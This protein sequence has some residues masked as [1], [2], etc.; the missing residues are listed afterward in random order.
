MG[1]RQQR[2]E[3][4][5]GGFGV[6]APALA[7][8][9]GSRAQVEAA[10]VGARQSG[11]NQAISALT[12]LA[13]F[14]TEERGQTL[15]ALLGGRT[16]DVNLTTGQTTNI[17]NALLQLAGL[18]MPQIVAGQQSSGSQSKFSGL[19]SLLSLASLAA[20]P[21]TGGASLGVGAGLGA[22]T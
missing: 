19:S 8:A 1:L 18:S 21:A 22:L 11:V 3:N 7:S 4:L 13:G 17:F 2:V 14:G 15:D 12:Q 10:N 5:L 9:L 20:A 6:D 16:Q